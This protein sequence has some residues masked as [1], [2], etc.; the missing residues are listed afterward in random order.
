M[1]ALNVL[2][3]L[4]SMMKAVLDE[5]VVQYAGVIGKADKT[6]IEQERIISKAD[7]D[8][9]FAFTRAEWERYVGQVVPPEG[10][11]MRLQP[12]ETGTWLA[13]F[14]QSTGIWKSVQALFTNDEGPP[15]RL[16]VGSYYPV[17]SLL[18][19]LESERDERGFMRITREVVKQ[20]E[21]ATR[22]ELGPAYSVWA[23][24]AAP[25]LPGSN[26][27]ASEL[28]VTPTLTGRRLFG[29]ND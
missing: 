26:L 24:P 1:A 22:L 3:R 28:I 29:G 11:T 14:N 9:I 15:I 23:N 4:L 21:Q 17:Y 18:E 6:A 12:L 20:I 27:V 5:V 7:A 10:W 25:A 8:M 16:F 13:R 2:S 19:G